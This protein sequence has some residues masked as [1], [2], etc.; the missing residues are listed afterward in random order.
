MKGCKGDAI[1]MVRLALERRACLRRRGRAM[2][3]PE[4]IASFINETW[5]CRPQEYF[6]AVYLN[7]ASEVIAVHEV[8]MGGIAQTAVDP[9]VLF[10][11]ALAAGA[12]AMVVAHTHPSGQPEPSADDEALT[13]MLVQG[14]RFLT[15]RVL[16]HLIVARGGRFYSFQ[17]AGRM[18]T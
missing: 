7:S 2:R 4:D 11:G 15:I 12:V 14:A 13:R 10:G 3:T 1:P 8:A 9:K 17:A 6:V 18:P 16:D 5:G